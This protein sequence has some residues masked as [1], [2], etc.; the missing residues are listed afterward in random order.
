MAINHHV[1]LRRASR[2][3][4]LIPQQLADQGL[5]GTEAVLHQIGPN[6]PGTPLRGK[7]DKPDKPD[8]EDKKPSMR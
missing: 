4:I 2:A 6:L 8:S 5:R 1:Q 7:P 3:F